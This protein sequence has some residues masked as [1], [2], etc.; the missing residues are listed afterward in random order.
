MHNVQLTRV[1]GLE[2]GRRARERRRR[3]RDQERSRE[4]VKDG[5]RGV[6]TP[7]SLNEREICPATG[8][9]TGVSCKWAGYS[10][11]HYFTHIMGGCHT[12]VIHTR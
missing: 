12:L 7:D 4:R 2:G 10:L 9:I 6:L 3:K 11:F 5:E 8:A 1:F